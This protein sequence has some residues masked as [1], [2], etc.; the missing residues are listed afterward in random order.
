MAILR[1][2]CGYYRGFSPQG[3]DYS[4]LVMRRITPLF[5]ARSS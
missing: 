3:Q 2:L 5:S 1:I 4:P